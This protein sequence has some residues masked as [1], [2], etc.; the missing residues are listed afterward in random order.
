MSL[1]VIIL[2]FEIMI[3]DA[4][5]MHSYMYNDIPA[6]EGDTIINTISEFNVNGISM[7][8]KYD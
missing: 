4:C 5:T 7:K 8:L 1:R 3:T 6:T 2:Q